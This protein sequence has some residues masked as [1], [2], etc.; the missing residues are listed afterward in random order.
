MVKVLVTDT[1]MPSF[2]I[3]ETILQPLGAKVHLASSSDEATLVAEAADSAAIMAGYAPVREPVIASAARGGCRAIVRYGIGYDNVDVAAADRHGIPVAN[4]PDYCTDEV[5]DHTMAMLLSHARRIVES[6]QSVRSGGWDIPKDQVPRLAGRRLGLLGLG[7]IGRRVAQRAQA[8]GLA[9]LAYDPI[10]PIDVPGVQSASTAQ[11]IYE[12]ADYIS[13]HVPLTD[14]T[15]HIIDREAVSKMKR[16]PLLINTARGGLVDLEAVMEGL[17]DGKLAG[18]ALDVFETEPLPVD[19]PLRTNPLAIITP[20]MSY[21]SNESEPDLIR[22]V[23]EE[24]ARALRG[25]PL[26]NPLTKIKVAA[27]QSGR[28]GE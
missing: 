12:S 24:V 16:K 10:A 4:V 19:H 22:R 8:F 1:D 17:A 9:V 20:H 23:A 21:Y 25:E 5:A 18:V 11:E 28:G 6:S 27:H 26:L 13:V 7:R 14:K 2:E 15:R 3:E